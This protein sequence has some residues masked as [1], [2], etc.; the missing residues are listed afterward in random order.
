MAAFVV[1]P[2]QQFNATF[3]TAAGVPIDYAT[4][5]FSYAINRSGTWPVNIVYTAASPGYAVVQKS[6]TGVYFVQLLTAGLKGD[7]KVGWQGLD[8]SGNIQAQNSAVYE[9]IDDESG[10]F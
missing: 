10:L 1:G 3:L 8:G 2:P 9:A 6:S 5:Q 4:V 7:W